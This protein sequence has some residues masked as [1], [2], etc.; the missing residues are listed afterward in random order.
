MICA[1]SGF[2]AVLL[3]PTAMLGTSPW[4]GSGLVRLDGSAKAMDRKRK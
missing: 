3:K 4:T 2:N 1:V